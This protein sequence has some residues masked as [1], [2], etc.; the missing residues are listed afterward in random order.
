MFGLKA[1]LWGLSGGDITKERGIL[2]LT[3]YEVLTHI[4]IK[5]HYAKADKEYNRLLNLR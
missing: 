4:Q 1:T 2:D 5:M 3:G